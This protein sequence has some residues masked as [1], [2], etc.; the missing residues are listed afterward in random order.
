MS[1]VCFLGIGGAGMRALAALEQ[2]KGVRVCGC[3]QNQ[4]IFNDPDLKEFELITE[5]EMR[6]RIQTCQR[7]VYSDAL[8]AQHPL[9]MMAQEF[10]I[11]LR[12]YQ[13]ELGDFSQDYHVIAVAGTHGKSSTTAFL[14][15]ILLNNKV[16]ASILLGA[17][18]PGWP[19]GNAWVGKNEWLVVEADEYRNHFWKLN[20]EYLI[21][22]SL[23]FDHPDFFKSKKDVYQSFQVMVDKLP[24]TGKLITDEQT[25]SEWKPVIKNNQLITIGN[26]LVGEIKI[27]IPGQHMQHNAALAVKVAELLG[28]ARHQAEAALATFPGLGR[29]FEIIGNLNRALIVS[30]YGHHPTEIMATIKGA[31]AHY[32]DKKI[33]AIIEPH[34]EDRLQEFQHDFVEA[35]SEADKVV[36]GPV[37][38]ARQ[39][40]KNKIESTVLA[41]E[42][43]TKNKPVIALTDWSELK[44]ILQ[45]E[46]QYFGL[47]VIFS[48]GYLDGIARELFN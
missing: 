41:D 9:L 13:E 4:D 45:K 35:L 43:E 31:R 40:G 29:R 39:E 30:D 23:D 42:L 44:E 21:V 46:S 6:D 3:D 7:V 19:L 11:S 2:S 10:N 14:G 15:H 48:A 34:T 33:L 17:K 24:A 1:Q 38:R 25:Y 26:D 12:P 18:V 47:I 28:V 5:K 20:P 27:P 8:T 16:E 36:V 22:T 37:Y 32:A